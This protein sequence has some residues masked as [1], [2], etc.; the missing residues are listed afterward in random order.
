M[1]VGDLV[2]LSAAGNKVQLNRFI[3]PEDVGFVNRD[4]N[5]NLFYIKWFRHISETLHYRYELKFAK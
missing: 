2:R 5:D 4:A 3:G 1:K